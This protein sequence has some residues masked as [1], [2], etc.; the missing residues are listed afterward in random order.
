M[1]LHVLYRFF[2]A[3]ERLLYVGI[4]NEPGRRFRKHGDTK[5]WWPTVARVQLAHFP[6]RE[7]LAAAERA[8]IAGEAPL[9]NVHYQA[10]AEEDEAPQSPTPAASKLV[11]LVGWSFHSLKEGVI[12]WQGRVINEV[13]PRI[14]RVVLFSWL[15]GQPFDTKVI[16]LHEMA[17]WRFF[18]TARMM[19]SSDALDRIVY[20]EIRTIH[21]PR[22][23]S[24]GKVFRSKQ[25][26]RE[27]EVIWR[28]AGY[29]EGMPWLDSPS[30][31][32]IRYPDYG[33]GYCPIT[34]GDGCR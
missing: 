12:E 8:A 34:E 17:G 27:I 21:C 25:D 4:T 5:A 18:P 10:E 24:I 33:C 31:D 7:A 26:S 16:E 29:R 23:S 3:E 2:D 32:D 30:M 1:A 9:H 6:D 15:D 22:C 19:S 14:Y 11:D 28:R 13:A 20:P